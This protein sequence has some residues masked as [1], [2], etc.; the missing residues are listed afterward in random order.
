M[1]GKYFSLLFVCVCALIFSNSAH[2]QNFNL[3]KLI[4]DYT[5]GSDFFGG[6]I[7]IEANGN[8]KIE[9]GGCTDDFFESGTYTLNA[10]GLHFKILKSSRKS[11]S[12]NEEVNLLEKNKEDESA[13]MP[14]SYKLLPIEWAKRIYLIKDEDLKEF[15]NAVNLGIEPR[16]SLSSSFYLGTFYV[17]VEEQS[18]TPP[19]LLQPIT[20]LPKLLDKWNSFLLEKPVTAKIISIEGEKNKVAIINKGEI[21]GLKVGMRLIINNQKP[22]LWSGAEIISVESKTAKVR[23]F[24]DLKVGDKISSKFIRSENNSDY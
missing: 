7:T 24:D 5:A 9:S 8:Y 22:S 21:D 4:G 23:L 14:T 10:D 6:T 1:I 13:K 17:R 3:E 16:D 2:G 12:D 18:K 15:I 11:H 20:G 19:F